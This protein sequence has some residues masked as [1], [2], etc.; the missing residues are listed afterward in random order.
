ME[1]T[2]DFAAL[3]HAWGHGDP[4]ARDQLF[5]EIYDDL[6]AV[7]T[8]RFQAERREHTLQPTAVVHELY[9]RLQRQRRVSWRNR[10]E[11]FAVIPELIRR[12]LVDHARKRLA[13]RRQGEAPQHRL[14]LSA[15]SEVP[16]DCP[17]E[18]CALKD[19]LRALERHDARGSRVV[20]LH[21]FEGLTFA[22]VAEALNV[23]QATVYRDWAHA[24]LWLRRH[25]CNPEAS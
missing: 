15:A 2:S 1:S 8:R 14:P 10:R 12:I 16:A 13:D 3:L 20:A 9:L 22:E 23:A 25:F 11:L 6:R 5:A 21:V 19:G 18:L 24:L 7:A 17:H 4:R